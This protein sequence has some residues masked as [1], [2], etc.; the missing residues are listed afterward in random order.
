[1]KHESCRIEVEIPKD[2][3]VHEV[4]SAVKKAL[5]TK[6]TDVTVKACDEITIIVSKF[7]DSTR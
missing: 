6:L 2:A 3:S 7:S 1:M 4:E 5:K